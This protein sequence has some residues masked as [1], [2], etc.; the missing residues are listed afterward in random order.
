MLLVISCREDVLW[1][2]WFAKR[3]DCWEPEVLQVVN[4]GLTSEFDAKRERESEREEC[5]S[6]MRRYNDAFF[7]LAWADRKSVV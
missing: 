7:A 4:K 3:F 1:F 2:I 5:K 6:R